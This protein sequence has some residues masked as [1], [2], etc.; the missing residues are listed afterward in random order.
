MPPFD[1]SHDPLKCIIIIAKLFVLNLN[2]KHENIMRN[3]DFK[4]VGLETLV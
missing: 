4:D 1:V 3:T 2:P